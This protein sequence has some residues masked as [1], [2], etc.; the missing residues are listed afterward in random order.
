MANIY[1][2]NKH[3]FKINTGTTEVPVWSGIAEMTSLTSEFSPTTET[4]FSF[5]QGGYQSALKT[6]I[7]M[8]FSTEVKRAYGDV[9]NDAIADTMFEVGEDCNKQF[10]WTMPNGDKVVFDAVVSVESTG[11]ETT[12]VETMSVT[13]TVIG[14]PTIT[15]AQ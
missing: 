1:P 11:G 14:K 12:A 2:V 3:T 7:A 8:S 4:W 9:G 6:G 5:E 10:Q 13:F 15:P